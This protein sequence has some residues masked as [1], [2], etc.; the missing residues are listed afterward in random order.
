[1][2]KN[3]FFII[4][5]FSLFIT[6]CAS[7][8]VPINS[9]SV[10]W[11][12][13]DI[14]P[15]DAASYSGKSKVIVR[16]PDVS[17]FNRIRQVDLGKIFKETISDKIGES[18]AT[19]VERN[20]PAKYREELELHV[21]KGG[22]Q[23]T[24]PEIAD[25]LVDIKVSQASEKDQYVSAS[26]G[27]SAKC[28][29]TAYIKAVAKVYKLP[30]LAVT[31]IIKIEGDR[32]GFTAARSRNCQYTYDIQKE[33][34]RTAVSR[35]TSD[36]EDELKN[37]FAPIAYVSDIKIEDGNYFFKL[38]SGTDSGFQANAEAAIFTLKRSTN[39]ISS[40]TQL[41]EYLVTEV[42][43]SDLISS[44]YAWFLIDD[45]DAALQ[46]H[47]GDYAKAKHKTSIWKTM[48]RKAGNAIQDFIPVSK[49]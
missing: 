27:T 24:G 8:K 7:N 48:L 23:Y 10:D 32:S 15:T 34:F 49:Q 19:I 33:L 17:Q 6:G 42:E 14:M 41:E 22:T 30:E 26:S 11:Q 2:N 28:H 36:V 4:I 18:G 21:M 40:R 47:I 9:G 37:A 29:I 46:I 5:L 1:M 12:M 45:K 43:I 39:A 31:S 3:S 38:S 16:A 20:I 35:A 25:Y 44:N 13:A